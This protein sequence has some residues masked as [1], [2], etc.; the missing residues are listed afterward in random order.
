MERQV[1][2][3]Y[4]AV[5]HRVSAGVIYSD[6]P[7]FIF[8]TLKFHFPFWNPQDYLRVLTEDDKNKAVSFVGRWE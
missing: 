6:Q 4:R 5:N 7:T 3:L 2:H 1:T 8:K